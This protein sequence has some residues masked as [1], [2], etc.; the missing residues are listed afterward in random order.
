MVGV[1]VIDAGQVQPFAGNA[2]VHSL[3]AQHANSAIG[4]ELGERILRPRPCVMVAETPEDAER[5]AEPGQR[6]DYYALRGGAEGEKVAGEG[7]QVGLEGI[8]DAHE[9]AN[10]VL[11]HE[12]A[13]MNVG[14][15]YDAEAVERLRQAC[16]T[17]RL[18][19]GFEVQPAIKQA[20]RT[21]HKRSSDG[22][23]GSV[24]QPLPACRR[25]GD[26]FGGVLAH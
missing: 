7:D 18:L 12:R 20:V 9:L 14:E 21:G 3:L 1:G 6:V 16:Q 22:S 17:N 24:L 5:G 11:V 15:L 26:V 19:S 13:D 4:K 25:G 8:G 10:L 23:S 2:E